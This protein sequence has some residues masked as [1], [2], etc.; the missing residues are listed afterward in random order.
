MV[1]L[2]QN[3]QNR[4]SAAMETKLDEL[5]R[6]LDKGRDRFIGIEHETDS[7]IEDIRAKVE[8]ECADES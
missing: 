2:I 1:F 3:S 7:E 6:A 5:I 4:D 8:S